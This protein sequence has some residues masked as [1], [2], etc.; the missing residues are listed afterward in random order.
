LIN[1]EPL[2]PN[3]RRLLLHGDTLKFG[4]QQL[5]FLNPNAI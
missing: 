3:E 5:V 4:D 2:K 1:N